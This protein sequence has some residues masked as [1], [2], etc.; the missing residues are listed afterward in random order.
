[1]SCT[2]FLYKLQ[3]FHFD[4]DNYYQLQEF[5]KQIED[6]LLKGI[7]SNTYHKPTAN[8]SSLCQSDFFLLFNFS[9]NHAWNLGIWIIY[10]CGLYTSFDSIVFSP[11]EGKMPYY[12]SPLKVRTL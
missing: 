11:I 8:K 5:E 4:C 10:E 3:L 7:L 12:L 1:M 6:M 2:W 9:Q